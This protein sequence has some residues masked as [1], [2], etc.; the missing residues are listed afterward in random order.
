MVCV[1]K[2]YNDEN[3]QKRAETISTP[4][5]VKDFLEETAAHLRGRSP[6]FEKD[7]AADIEKSKNFIAILFSTGQVT[8]ADVSIP[9]T[10]REALIEDVKNNPKF[11]VH[12]GLL[13]LFYRSYTHAM[14]SPDR[15]VFVQL[16]DGSYICPDYIDERQITVLASHFSQRFFNATPHRSRLLNKLIGFYLN[17]IAMKL[18]FESRFDYMNKRLALF[19]ACETGEKRRALARKFPQTKNK[20]IRLKIQNIFSNMKTGNQDTRRKTTKELKCD[21]KSWEEVD[22]PFCV[23]EYLCVVSGIAWAEG[24]VIS[25]DKFVTTGSRYNWYDCILMMWRLNEAKNAERKTFETKESFQAY[26]EANRMADLHP[27]EALVK[28]LRV[29]F[30]ALVTHSF[31]L[32]G[33]GPQE[34]FDDSL[35]A[36]GVVEGD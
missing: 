5:N 23:F 12:T 29:Q 24:F 20:I 2:G 14:A 18:E 21:F 11:N 10:N 22:D 27:L 4:G 34:P 13:A 1:K 25:I 8:A 30:K 15:T 35:K 28:I 6:N 32:H 3:N 26:V 33:Y 19:L 17:P 9:L 7:N 31:I 36:P 16:D